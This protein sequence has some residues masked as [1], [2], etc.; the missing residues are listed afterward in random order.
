MSD[1]NNKDMNQKKTRSKKKT[2]PIIVGLVVAGIVVAG[3]SFW[4]YFFPNPF[5]QSVATKGISK[6]AVSMTGE[7]DILIAY[8]SLAGNRAYTS[9]EVD[10]VASAS[11]KIYDDQPLGHAEIYALAAQKTTGGDLFFIETSEKYPETYS[12]ALGRHR[13]EMNEN[14]RPALSAHVE[15]MDNYNTIVLIYPNWMSNLPQAVLTFLEEYDFSGKTIVPIATST[16][17]GLG[18]SPQQ[19]KGAC[20]TAKVAD[21]F[22][23]RNEEG[24][25][26]FL[27]EAGYQK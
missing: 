21:G 18:S 16:A 1:T 25:R 17:L 22:S 2:V 19:I 10:A 11:L 4:V 24:V 8:F 9:D 26:N 12:E 23:A 7:S 13:N 6:G 3:F 14:A 27:T 20:P 15:N 5:A